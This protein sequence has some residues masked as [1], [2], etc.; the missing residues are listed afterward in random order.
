VN[1][2]IYI[3]LRLFND[4]S[5]DMMMTSSRNSAAKHYNAVLRQLRSVVRRHLQ[6]SQLRSLRSSAECIAYL[7]S[8][9]RSSGRCRGVS[10]SSMH[11]IS[12][13]KHVDL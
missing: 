2:Y 10:T 3:Y 11:R 8:V 1:A 13:R 12:P 6:N 9:Q 5:A 4:T 7:A